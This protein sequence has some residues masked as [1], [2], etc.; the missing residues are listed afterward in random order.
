MHL[1]VWRFSPGSASRALEEGVEIQDFRKSPR[2]TGWPRQA[3]TACLAMT[4]QH[5]VSFVNYLALIFIEIGIST[6][7]LQLM[8]CF[9]G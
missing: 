7:F 9:P 8:V 3:L 1:E 2:R 4:N 5:L 6:V